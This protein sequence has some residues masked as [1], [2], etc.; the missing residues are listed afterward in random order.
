M[1]IWQ[2]FVG[3]IADALTTF[4]GLIAGAGIPYSF[5]FA[6]ILFTMV[7]KLV[8][9]PLTLQ[10]LRS[11]RAMQELQP[12]LQKMQKKHK[13]DKEKMAQAQMELYKEHGVSPV[14]GCLPMLVQFPIWIALYRALF[15]LADAGVLSQGFFWIPSLAEPRDL[16]WLWP[17]PPSV[18]WA[19][20]AAF[21]V[22]P[23]LTVVSQIVV[24]KM[25]TPAKPDQKGDSKQ[26]SGQAMQQSMNQ[27]MVFMPFMFG[28]FAMQV[29]QGLA[30]YWFTSNVFSMIQQYFITGWGSLRPA[31]VGA[32]ASARLVGEAPG[33]PLDESPP[34]AKRT[35]RNGRRK[36]K[37]KR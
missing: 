12:E 27:M 34:G 14:G 20:A 9:L 29:P 17:L 10:Q 32:K 26:D 21:M 7:I 6:I 13:G 3:L 16:T 15:R 18:G 33:P 11:S 31:A 4:N 19:T 35:K 1:N 30:L 36:R 28:F 22:L 5:G 24:Q 8:T 23:V 37:K 2:A 25:M